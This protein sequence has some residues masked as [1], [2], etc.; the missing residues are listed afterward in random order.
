MCIR[1]TPENRIEY[2]LCLLHKFVSSLCH[3]SFSDMLL[4]YTY[5]TAVCIY[6]YVRTFLCW[7]YLR[8]R[9]LAP[10][11]HTIF[12]SIFLPHVLSLCVIIIFVFFFLDFTVFD[13]LSLFL[14][15]FLSAIYF[16]HAFI[17]SF[18]QDEWFVIIIISWVFEKFIFSSFHFICFTRWLFLSSFVVWFE[19]SFTDQADSCYY[20]LCVCVFLALLFW[21][22]KKEVNCI[23]SAMGIEQCARSWIEQKCNKQNRNKTFREFHLADI[24]NVT[25]LSM[26]FWRARIWHSCI[27]CV[28]VAWRAF[29]RVGNVIGLTGYR[30]PWSFSTDAF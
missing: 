5:R 13:S 28:C 22:S 30:G 17:V 1:T 11:I 12:D 25:L 19:V 29:V 6:I 24:I 18:T 27:V 2:F 7:Y 15:M 14:C 23:R 3:R 21:Q 4:M 16:T 9:Y 26:V 10:S 20:Y 8:Y